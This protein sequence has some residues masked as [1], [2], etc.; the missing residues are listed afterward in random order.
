MRVPWICGCQWSSL[1]SVWPW[2]RNS[3]CGGSFFKLSACSAMSLDSTDRSHWLMTSSAPEAANTLESMG[4]HSTDVI[5]ALCCLKL[6]T[7][8]PDWKRCKKESVEI[9]SKI[10][11]RRM[12]SKGRTSKNTLLTYSWKNNSLIHEHDYNLVLSCFICSH[13]HMHVG[14]NQLYLCNFAL[15]EILYSN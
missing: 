8:C 2:C 7:G 12:W 3:S 4:F 13:T 11:N 9:R 1:I 10:R 6:A 15:A 14:L 5:G